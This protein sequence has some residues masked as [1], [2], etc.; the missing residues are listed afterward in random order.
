MIKKIEE[1][2]LDRLSIDTM[3][4]ELISRKF[5]IPWEKAF[6]NF[7]AGLEMGISKIPKVH[8]FQT[9]PDHIEWPS[10]FTAIDGRVLRKY[11]G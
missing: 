10:A 5:S 3:E 11:S 1:M 4:P 6:D 9:L 7:L 8:V 2:A